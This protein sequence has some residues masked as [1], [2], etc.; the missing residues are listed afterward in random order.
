MRQGF[1]I[2]ELM[3]VFIIPLIIAAMVGWVMNIVQI[4][5]LIDDPITGLFIFKCVGVLL[6]PLGAVLGI[7]GMF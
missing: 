5:R 6:A 1:T 2:I 7:V 4:L 3:F